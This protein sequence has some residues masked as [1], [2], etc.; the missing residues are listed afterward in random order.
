MP[1]TLIRGC[2]LLDPSQR[3]YAP[4][5]I[6]IAGRTI[7]AVHPVISAERADRVIEA[8]GLVAA[9]GFV[10]IHVHLRQPG[11]E[12]SE[13]I[14]SGT[15]AAARGG[16]TTVYAMPNTNPVCDSSVVVRYVIDRAEEAGSVRVVPIGAVTL[17]QKGEDLVD[18][19]ALLQSGAGAFSDDGRPVANAEVMRRALECCRDLGAVIFDHCEDMN[20]T[21]DGVMHEGAVS[22]R[23]GLKGIPRLS[24]ST[25]VA[26]DSALA[27]ATGGRLHI[28]HVS[29]KDSVHAIRSMKRHGAPVTA[30]V[31]PHH[32]T[33]THEA[34]E[35]IDAGP[36]SFSTS[37]KM[38]PPLCAEEDRQVLIEALT[39]GTIDCIATDHAPHSP[40][41]KDT[42]FEDAPFGIVGLESAFPVLYNEFV[43]TGKWTLDFLVEKMT[44]APARVVNQPWGTLKPGGSA[45]IVL[46]DLSGTTE[47][48]ADHL[49]SK[50]RNSPW[51]GR[52]FKSRIAA[53]FAQGT[54]V[55]ADPSRFPKGASAAG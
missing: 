25:L 26:R 53:T 30:E 41:S 32:L 7:E 20:L 49:G 21:G 46:L 35:S 44:A 11:G 52:T 9:P 42:T 3:L 5:S 8:G 36:G 39:D 13:T 15:D 19:G 18:F 29:N 55:F 10:D 50:S 47:F 14:R 45:D 34:V 28:C 48:S 22:F 2:T 6:L 40:A 43:A 17:G 23:L 4:M 38:K 51:L 1:K 54:C 27:L 16:F 12:G 31:S 37:A 33:L 24:E